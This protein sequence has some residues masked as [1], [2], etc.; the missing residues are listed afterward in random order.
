MEK[1]NIRLIFFGTSNFAVP[2]LTRLVDSGFSP[3]L[4]M[5][6]PDAPVGRKKILTPPPIKDAAARMGLPI[7]QPTS[8]KTDETALVLEKISPDIFILAAYGKIVPRRILEIPRI[9][10]LNVH[11]SLLPKFRGASPIHAVILSGETETGATIIQMD[12]EVDHG[13]IVAQEKFLL[14]GDETYLSLS[15]QLAELSAELLLDALP[16]YI[17]EKTVLRPQHHEKASF[18]GLIKPT[19][20]NIDWNRSATEIER[21]VRAYHLWPTAY[22]HWRKP[23]ATIPLRINILRSRVEDTDASPKHPGLI[24]ERSGKLC[25]ETGKGSLLVER[26]QISGRNETDAAAFLRGHRD[27]LG[28]VLI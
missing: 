12:S 8:L 10:S 18:T 26:L 1:S 3:Q 23:G 14:R 5:T 9:G 6:Q 4:V 13:P 7:F 20:A 16:S 24:S 28:T 27:I 15:S 22:S 21:M 2:I 11:P 17:E 19:E 25:V